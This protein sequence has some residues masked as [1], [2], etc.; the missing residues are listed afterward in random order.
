ME[1]APRERGPGGVDQHRVHGRDG[2]IAD[3]ARAPLPDQQR[4]RDEVGGVEGADAE[5]DHVVED[6]GGSEDDQGQQDGRDGDD[7]D[8]PL[9]DGLGVDLGFEVNT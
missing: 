4:G 6:G 1:R 2:G 8:G 3:A 9:R 5:G 7:E